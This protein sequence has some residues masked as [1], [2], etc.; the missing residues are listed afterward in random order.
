MSCSNPI[1]AAV[2]ADY[3]IAALA[4]PEEEAV[5]EHLFDCDAC[6][7]RLREVIELAEGVR[8]LARE[9]SLRMVVSEEF[10][11]RAVEE[12]LRVR[13]YAPPPG[14]GVECTVTAEDEILIGR[15]AANLSGSKRVDLCICDERGV[16]QLR[17]PDIPVHPGA[18]SVVF[19]ESITSAKAAP[20]NKT[21]VRLFTIDEAGGERLLGEYTFNHTRS[22]PGPGAW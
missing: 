6:G 12:G 3:W 7:V 18:S 4:K 15:L 2:L 17:L 14:G 8:K 10:L 19:Q 16:E 9:G 22:L 11:K 13:R 1:D 21:I 5:E 20:T